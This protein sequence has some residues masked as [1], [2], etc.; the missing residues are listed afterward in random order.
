MIMMDGYDQNG[1]AWLGW[2]DMIMM[3]GDDHD[4]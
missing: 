3:A 1:R 2:M 4:G